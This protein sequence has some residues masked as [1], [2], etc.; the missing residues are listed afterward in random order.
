[1]AEP[2]PY[3]TLIARAFHLVIP[4]RSGSGKF[5]WNE[6]EI[7]TNPSLKF[8]CTLLRN[9]LQRKFKPQVSFFFSAHPTQ[10]NL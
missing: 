5:A 3:P 6:K 4:K 10:R 2:M 1:M 7:T 8:H 9:E